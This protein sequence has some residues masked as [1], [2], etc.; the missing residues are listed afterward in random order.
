M[1]NGEEQKEDFKN[2]LITNRDNLVTI[3]KTKN[4]YITFDQSKVESIE[5]RRIWFNDGTYE[6]FPNHDTQE[7]ERIVIT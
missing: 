1:N 2:W 7:L 4:S 3:R 5:D 6:D